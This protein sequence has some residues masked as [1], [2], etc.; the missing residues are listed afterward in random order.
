MSQTRS[1]VVALLALLA[2]V[3]GLS[4]WFELRGGL[5][6]DAS[7]LGALPYQLGDWRGR[8]LPLEGEVERIL[9]ADFNLQRVYTRNADG[10]SVW[11]Y[12]GYYG[13]RRGGRPEHTPDQ[14]Y[15]SAGWRIDAQEVVAL[16][17]PG[18]LRA[19]EYQVSRDGERQLVH[20][21]YR[22]VHRS[23]MLDN[24]AVSLDQLA[25]RLRSGRADGALVRV[26]TGLRR[27]DL[28]R[29]RA[30]LSDFA[31]ELEP[32]LARRWPVEFDAGS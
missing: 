28:S 18:A 25:G 19:N 2:L 6:V 13:T 1:G 16:D 24:L 27:G 11:L 21:W 14:C 29:A 5:R 31:S 20:F 10:A 23:G 9:R 4:W 8:E 17:A 30:R 26:S 3:G 12:V 32:E 15:P 7:R 22:S